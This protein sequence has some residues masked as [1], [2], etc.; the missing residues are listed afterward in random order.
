MGTAPWSSRYCNVTAL[1]PTR[2]IKS[3][4]NF[5]SR[6]VGDQLLAPRGVTPIS[7]HYKNTIGGTGENKT[8]EQT[9][10]MLG[11][12]SEQKE[13]MQ[14]Y[15]SDSIYGL[16]LAWITS[17]NS[18]KQL[19]CRHLLTISSFTGPYLLCYCL[20]APVS[21]VNC[22]CP[23]FHAN[24]L[25]A[26]FSNQLSFMSPY[27]F[28]IRRDFRSKNPLSGFAPKQTKEL[29]AWRATYTVLQYVHRRDTADQI[30]AADTVAGRSMSH[31]HE[32]KSCT[33]L[34][35]FH[36]ALIPLGNVWIQLFSLQL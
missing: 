23:W 4:N 33:R 32:F 18:T 14:H 7:C 10:T 8:N 19:E 36:I 35:A 34:I 21:G 5:P 15:I 27:L 6:P 29:S 9:W 13:S 26:P 1:A 24:R 2:H 22:P 16:T 20:T 28:R 12:N 30:H 25:S 11:V 31:L 17:E 3:S